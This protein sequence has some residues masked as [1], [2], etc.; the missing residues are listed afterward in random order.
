MRI[1]AVIPARYAST[2]FPA[3]P[4]AKIAGKS[5]IQR[6][7]E[8]VSAI[9]SLSKCIIATDH[10][11]IFQV[12]KSFGAEVMM[13]D[14]NHPS[15]TDR[16]A[17]VLTKTEETFDFVINI[18]GDEPF[19]ASDQIQTLLSLLHPNTELATLCKAIEKSEDLLDINV[20]KVVKSLQNDA[21]YFSRS[22]IPAVRDLSQGDWTSIKHLHFKHLGIYAYRADVL[23]KICQLAPTT[24]EEAEKLEQLRWLD[25]GYRIKISE[26]KIETPT[27]DRPEDIGKAEAWMKENSLT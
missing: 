6:V 16:V 15:G 2:R 27:I 13:T 25:H 18:Q 21:L 17:E 10:E 4:L 23:L 22:P 1:L 8:R 14:S 12:A 3:K 7:W 9:T 20:V 5:M 24:L 26:T 11:T 19:V